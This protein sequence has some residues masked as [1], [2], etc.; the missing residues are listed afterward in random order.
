MSKFDRDYSVHIKAN[1]Y[2]TITTEQSYEWVCDYVKATLK[3][4]I[5]KEERW[6]EISGEEIDIIVEEE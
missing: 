5:L 3:D 2:M 1:W 4:F 6:G